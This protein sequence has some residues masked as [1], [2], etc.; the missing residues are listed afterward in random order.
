M[1]L[2]AMGDLASD[3]YRQLVLLV[4]DDEANGWPFANYIGA[5]L[6]PGE[7]VESW[8]RDTDDGPGYSILVDL[9]RC[10][11][12][13]LPWLAQLKGVVLPPSLDPLGWRDY[14][15]Q[16]RGLRRHSLQALIDAGQTHLTGMKLVRVVER[17]G[18]SAYD[19]TVITR[20]A[21]TPTPTVTLADFMAAKRIGIRLAHIVTDSPLIDEGTRFID[22][23]TATIDAAVLSDVV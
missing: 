19:L 21:E 3:V 15:R 5:M 11:Q 8:A 2:P 4:P 22:S 12:V 10:P 13:A 9:D 20:T 6:S 14:I 16:A 18:P 1:P 23:A 7:Q 17:A